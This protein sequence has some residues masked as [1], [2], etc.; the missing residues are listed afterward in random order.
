M[1][2]T[3]SLNDSTI[4]MGPVHPFVIIGERI[5]PTR[6]KKLA[7]AMAAGDFSVIQEEARVQAQAGAHVLDVN[8]GVPGCEEPALLRAATLAVM[9]AVKL[10]LCLDSANP[11]ALAAALAVYPGKALINSTT[12]E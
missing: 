9:D 7:D 3:L 8:A 12:A 5:N 2:T 4:V 11:D 1:D 6:R 10:P